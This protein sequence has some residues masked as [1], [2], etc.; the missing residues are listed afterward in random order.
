MREI[1]NYRTCFAK[2]CEKTYSGNFKLIATGENKNL[3]F[4]NTHDTT[5]A[6]VLK[7]N[8]DVF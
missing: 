4:Y 3:F 1:Y 8:I 6:A 5:N 2:S 7:I